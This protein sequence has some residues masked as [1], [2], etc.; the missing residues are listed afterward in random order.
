MNNDNRSGDETYIEAIPTERTR[1]SFSSFSFRRL[2]P[3]PSK[4]N[5]L[6]ELY[7][8]GRRRRIA[9][10][11]DKTTSII[12]MRLGP[13]PFAESSGFYN[14]RRNILQE[15]YPQDE[16]RDTVSQRPTDEN[17]HLSVGGDQSKISQHRTH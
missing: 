1:Q 4:I 11:A 2:Q 9:D 10:R 16:R 3:G 12:F 14:Q 8:L 6:P 13:I 15:Q 5:P 17:S 7:Q